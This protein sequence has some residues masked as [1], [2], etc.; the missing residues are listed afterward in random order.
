MGSETSNGTDIQ[1]ALRAL[2]SDIEGMYRGA[3]TSDEYR[4]SEEFFG[5][6][7]SANWAST[8]SPSSGARLMRARVGAASACRI[9][10]WHTGLDV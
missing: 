6:S 8:A 5:R 3:E 9:A 7:P 1:K 10:L 2:L 4:H